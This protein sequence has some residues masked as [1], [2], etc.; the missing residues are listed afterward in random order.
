[1]TSDPENRFLPPPWPSGRKKGIGH[2]RLTPTELGARCALSFNTGT[3]DLDDFVEVVLGL[4]SGRLVQLMHRPHPD[5][6]FDVFADEREETKA[7]MD[8]VIAH[9]RLLPEEYRVFNDLPLAQ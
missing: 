6:G 2:I 7:R 8:E 5:Y 9:L 1:M 4:E 3:D